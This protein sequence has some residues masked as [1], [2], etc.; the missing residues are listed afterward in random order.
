MK[1]FTSVF[2]AV[3]SLVQAKLLNLASLSQIGA[4]EAIVHQT[5]HHIGETCKQFDVWFAILLS[6]ERFDSRTLSVLES[7]RYCFWQL[8]ASLAKLFSW[9]DCPLAAPQVHFKLMASWLFE[10]AA[11]A[12]MLKNWECPSGSS[13]F[14]NEVRYHSQTVSDLSFTLDTEAPPSVDS[15]LTPSVLEA[16]CGGFPFC[17]CQI[18]KACNIAKPETWPCH[19][20][21]CR[22]CMQSS[23]PQLSLSQ[24]RDCNQ[25]VKKNVN[26]C[27][28][29]WSANITGLCCKRMCLPFVILNTIFGH[30]RCLF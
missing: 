12:I 26:E 16:I 11:V 22:P 7:Q 13:A 20:C 29:C 30:A 2:L 15:P 24:L 8:G 18:P 17:L 9:V 27:Q 28:L 14:G 1:V 21:P 6:S 23:L 5:M 10:A 19:T 25:G 4:M 3:Q